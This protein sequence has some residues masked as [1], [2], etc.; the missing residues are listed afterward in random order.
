MIEKQSLLFVM[1][2]LVFLKDNLR[3]VPGDIFREHLHQKMRGSLGAKHSRRPI[4]VQ[5]LLFFLVF[6]Y[7]SPSLTSIWFQGVCSPP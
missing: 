4:P 1:S 5:F 7:K 6:L 2:F 3:L